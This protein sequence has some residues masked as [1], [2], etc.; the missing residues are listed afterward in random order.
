MASV[1][2]GFLVKLGFDVDKD[3]LQKFQSTV[4]GVS[5]RVMAVGKAATATGVALGAVFVKATRDVN[6]LYVTTNN[7]GTT[8]RSLT[9]IS[10]A[11]ERVGG[12]ST[13]VSAAFQNLASN[14]K[15]YGQSFED[16]L[17]NQLGVS[18]YDSRGQLRDMG[19]VF[20]ELR[21]ELARIAETDPGLA[22]AQADAIG[23]GVAFD[24]I[25]KK[26]F[27]DELLRA[28][29]ALAAMGTSLDDNAK[30]AHDLTNSFSRLW[31][32]VSDGAKTAALD[33]L[34]LTGI[35]KW[36]ND[37]ATSAEKNI[38]AA[39]KTLKNTA[40]QYLNGDRSVSNDL[41]TSFMRRGVAMGSDDPEVAALLEAYGK[42]HAGD[43]TA[44][45]NIADNWNAALSESSTSYGA[46]SNV[47]GIR[48]RNPGNLRAGVGQTGSE[49]GYATF[50]SMVDGYKAMVTQLAMYRNA[51]LT[52]V[53]S[54]IRKWAPPG[55]NN[56]NAYVASVLASMRKD[57]GAGL[58]S[59]TS[60]DLTNPRVMDS[61]VDAMIDHENGAGAS[62]YFQGQAYS[63]ALREAISTSRI[64]KVVSPADRIGN[65]VTV[66]QNITV[67]G[68]NDPMSTARAIQKQTSETVNR[69]AGSNI[70]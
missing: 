29:A 56:T 8:I 14:I 42:M 60:L 39:I 48:N 25:L 65:N 70:M 3:G 15:L 18:L 7:T 16:L 26:D 28:N 13:N 19:D 68:S 20:V 32:T 9:A 64:S 52:N 34:E 63:Q 49:G 31:D 35:D 67:Q 30:R 33:F 54:I 66:N 38:P 4:S 10:R 57:L 50:G 58:T 44:V 40:G 24:D 47:R 46:F 51:G 21:N 36:L 69:N 27:P 55:E 2:E 37:I 5:D 17:K 23:L 6:K 43:R 59:M 61:L 53:E 45:E 11:V 62:K 41:T 22:R 1:L 12:D